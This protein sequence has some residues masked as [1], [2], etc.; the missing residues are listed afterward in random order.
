LILKILVL[1]IGNVILQDDGVGPAIVRELKRF[2]FPLGVFLETTN[3]S[4]FPLL[5]LV[6]GC[7]TL[8]IVD[9]T[10]GEKKPGEITWEPVE[11]FQPHNGWVNHHTMDLFRVLDMGKQLGIEMPSNIKVLTIGAR[12][13]TSFGQVL[14]PEVAAAVPKAAA[15]IKHQIDILT[16]EKQAASE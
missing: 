15:E 4:G 14:T 6:T 3:L 5:D 9:A 13:V 10:N 7:D 8:I 11:T 1:G 16:K 2:D 12:D